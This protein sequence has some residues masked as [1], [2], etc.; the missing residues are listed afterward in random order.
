[1]GTSFNTIGFHAERCD[2]CGDCMRACARAKSGKE[3]LTNSRIRIQSGPSA[4]TYAVSLCL[5]CG[6][7]KCVAECP[8]AALVKNTTTGVIDFDGDACSDC[9]ACVGACSYDGI[10]VH[11]TTGRVIKCDTCDGDPACVAACPHEALEYFTA[12]KIFNKYGDRE[13]L[14]VR[15]LMGCQGCNSELLMRHT[16]RRVGPDTVL[17]APPGCVPG[18]GSVGFNGITGCKVPIFHS[19]LTNTASMLTGIKR[20]YQ[21]MGRD[22]LALAMAGDGGTAD[23]GFAALSGAAG[24]DDPMLYICFDNEGYM[25]TGVQASG[26][27]PYGSWTSTTPVGDSLRG[28]QAEAKNLPVIMMMHNCSY[29][30]TA[31]TG[32]LEDYYEKLDK[33]VEVAKTGMAYLHVHTPCPTGWR[34]PPHLISEVCRMQVRTNFVMLWEY[35]PA[36]GVRLTRSVDK[37]EPAEK[38]LKMI[39]KYKH[40]S[41]EQIAHIQKSVNQKVVYLKQVARYAPG[42][43]TCQTTPLQS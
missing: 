16:L 30:A 34:I 5:Q 40:L 21:R 18:I 7:P 3:V 12:A 14:F 28:A 29:V 33:A 17:A 37:P 26:V 6:N 11:E 32:Y 23:C 9:Q 4:N 31:S 13:D 38:Y 19:L 10:S 43:E 15:G 20:Q 36:T 1:M 35:T 25:N 22:V 42:G 2:G 27:T 24:R 41:A 39:G 8:S